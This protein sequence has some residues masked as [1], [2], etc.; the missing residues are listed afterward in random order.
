MFYFILFLFI[1]GHCLLRQ[2]CGQFTFF[3]LYKELCVETGLKQLCLI[4]VI[5]Q[6]LSEIVP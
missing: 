1:E 2:E 3:Q 4:L 6:L 5:F